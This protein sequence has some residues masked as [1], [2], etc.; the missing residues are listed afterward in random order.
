MKDFNRVEANIE[1][2]TNLKLLTEQ[3]VY[4]DDEKSEKISLP[5]KFIVDLKDKVKLDVINEIFYS[6]EIAVL[7]TND[8]YWIIQEYNEIIKNNK[9]ELVPIKLKSGEEFSLNEIDQANSINLEID[10]NKK[11]SVIIENV[12]EVEPNREYFAV[13]TYKKLKEIYNSGVESYNFE[14]QREATFEDTKFG[15]ITRPTIYPENVEG[16]KEAMLEGKFKS[17]LISLNALLIKNDTTKRY[18]YDDKRKML[19]IFRADIID[20]FHRQL[21]CVAAL[22][23]N[24]DL[25]GHMYLRFTNYDIK[26]AMTVVKQES[27][28]SKISKSRMLE[29]DN[30]IYTDIV[31]ALNNNSDCELNNKFGTF[32]EVENNL[33]LISKS[34]FAISLEECFN[35]QPR[36]KFFVQDYLIDFYNYIV[37]IFSNEFDNPIDSKLN[38]VVCDNNMFI[39][40]NYIASKLYNDD[41]WSR[42]LKNIINNIDFNN[43]NEWVELGIKSKSD[44]KKIRNKIYKFG[45]KLIERTEK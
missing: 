35:I 26:D 10:N 43:S 37:G 41:N 2:Q 22:T 38:K 8:L 40:Y 13:I 33:K 27:L 4:K 6:K 12:T 5:L 34:T 11:N 3:V 36:D 19:E 17:N 14:T 32:G 42:K 23:E 1:I 18:V 45:E 15:V 24:P 29:L 9:V 31:D 25:K 44:S 16:I 39:L 30:S 20:G 7:N 21:G 28:G